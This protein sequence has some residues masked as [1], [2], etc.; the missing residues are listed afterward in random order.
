M[1]VPFVVGGFVVEGWIGQGASGVV[2]RARRAST[3]GLV[4]LKV[5][6]AGLA[7]DPGF[8]GAFRG[9]AAMMAGIDSPHCVR[10]FELVEDGPL[11]AIASELV[12]GASLKAVLE[13]HGR[14]NA[15]QVLAV[16]SGAL[17]GLAALHA[18]GIVHRDIKPANILVDRA[19]VSKLAD[20]GL[21][22][23][24]SSLASSGRSPVGSP[25][26]MSPE[27][28]RGAAVGPPSDIY[29][30]AAMLFELLTDRLPFEAGN[31]D[32]LL[33]ANQHAPVP[34][35]RAHTQA[36]SE[37][38]AQ[39][40]IEGLAKNPADRP[41]DADVFLA[42]LEQIAET[43][44]PDWTRTAGLA[45]LV[46][47]TLAGLTELAQAVS[48]G[49]IATTTAT[50]GTA[51]AAVTAA[52]TDITGPP[53]PAHTTATTT[54]ESATTARTPGQSIPTREPPNHPSRVVTK[55][56]STFSTHPVI[57]TVATVAVI[58][59]A[60]GVAIG[61]S[62][63]TSTA[64]PRAGTTAALTRCLTGTWQATSTTRYDT[65]NDTPVQITLTGPGDQL[66]FEQ[67]GTFIDLSATGSVSAG[68]LDG[69][70]FYEHDQGELAG[71]WKATGPGTVVES[72]INSSQY[73]ALLY[74]G[75][76]HTTGSGSYLQ[77]QESL[78]VTC[79]GGT[80][81][82]SEATTVNGK[83]L[84]TTAR[85][86]RL[87]SAP[88]PPT[89]LSTPPSG[90]SAVLGGVNLDGY[91]RT[92]AQLGPNPTGVT[93]AQDG[94]RLTKPLTGTGV[95]YA[96]WECGGE[97]PADLNMDNACQWTWKDPQALARPMDID[98]AYSWLCYR[99][100]SRTPSALQISPASG[101]VDTSVTVSAS[102]CPA[103]TLHVFY[104]VTTNPAQADLR[105]G[106]GEPPCNGPFSFDIAIG[107]TLSQPS[108][109]VTVCS[110]GPARVC[111][112][113][114]PGTTTA[115]PAGKVQINVVCYDSDGPDFLFTPATFDFTGS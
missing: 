32:E 3:G 103:G 6:D 87:A 80:L 19:G 83:T 61:T 18:A 57:S 49:T 76:D 70:V 27:Q 7:S 34:D 89:P 44:H 93:G 29:A 104:G 85:Y 2:Y 8:V 105:G 50:A 23:P 48:G 67:D 72:G 53:T 51:D 28:A 78:T 102:G 30:C 42:R 111:T 82:T 43:D 14:L 69:A 108:P 55:I 81:T 1:G 66:T 99:T 88:P 63:G 21:A 113:G 16:L 38:M 109:S 95:A 90:Q 24:V 84:T 79:H 40:I 73:L 77:S 17:S 26:Y 35:P 101:G 91:C 62:G 56:T 54:T 46:T 100:G 15:P 92:L 65:W 37:P 12:D 98:L 22:R 39:L 25:A 74:A 60:I 68:T 41:P 47:S 115:V 86:T 31:L 112:G 71:K 20:F 52:G 10:F 36:I 58:A 4:S 5:L 33:H 114:S 75:Y 13:R 107:A 64:T 9:E 96:N 97:K 11:V 110:S 45:G 59:G 94:A 106:G